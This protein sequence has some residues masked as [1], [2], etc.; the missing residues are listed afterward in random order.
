MGLRTKLGMAVISSVI[1]ATMIAGGTFAEFTSQQTSSG[2]TFTAGTLTMDISNKNA[3]A[4]TW[5]TPSGFKPGDTLTNTINFNNSGSIDAHHVFF[6][7]K[8]V[9]H[10]GGTNDVNLADK[11]IV[12]DI[13]DT[14]DGHDGSNVMS[15]VAS[16]VGNK[17]AVLTLAE[18]ETFS[19]GFYSID[20]RSGGD[21]TILRAGNQHDYSLTFSFK[22]DD[23]AN[24]DYQAATTDFDLQCRATQNTDTGSAVRI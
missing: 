9:S 8:N 4:V 16:S 11:I 6:D 13:H 21:G 2:N 15:Q 12:T 1:G 20:D 22:F 17:D 23:A 18:L 3:A 5:N 10:S 14:F 24:D 19:A 7:F